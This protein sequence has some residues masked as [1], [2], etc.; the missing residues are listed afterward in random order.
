MRW[1]YNIHQ[2]GNQTTFHGNPLITD[3]L[4]L[5]DPVAAA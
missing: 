5:I 2:D 1:S 4:V 3:H